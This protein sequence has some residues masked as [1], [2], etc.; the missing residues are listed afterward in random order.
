MKKPRNSLKPE[1]I[2]R[3]DIAEPETESRQAQKGKEIHPQEEG[4]HLLRQ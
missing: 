4:L 2:G 3:K 1:G